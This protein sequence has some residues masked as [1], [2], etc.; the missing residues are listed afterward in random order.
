MF[1]SS[2]DR[3]QVWKDLHRLT[4]TNNSDVRMYA[5]YSLGKASVFKA[6]EAKDKCHVEGAT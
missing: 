2:P 1:L 3:M 4:K 5:Y 6:I